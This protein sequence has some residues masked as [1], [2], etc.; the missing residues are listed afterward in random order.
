MA[1]RFRVRSRIEGLKK[2]AEGGEATIYQYNSTTVLKIY[3]PHVDLARKQQKVKEFINL[4][5]RFPDV[6]VIGPS[7][8][9]LLNDVF[10]GYAMDK[11]EN[12]EDLHM[13]TKTKYL[14]AAGL[15]NKDVLTIMTFIGI[16]LEYLHA[17]G[18][19]IGD[20]S[21][22]N[23]QI[24]GKSGYFI[25]VDSWGI[26]G[27]FPPDAYTVL[28][29]CP[30]SYARDGSIKFSLENE[31]YN[32]AVLAFNILTRI[33]PFGGTYLPNKGLSIPERMKKKISILGRHAKDI[34]IPKVI[35]SWK[36]I[37]P[38]LEKD[39]IDIFE[40]GKR[41]DITPDLKELLDNMKYCRTHGIY[42]YSKYNECPICNANA[43][44]QT[45]PV[46]TI[47]TPG[48]T[49]PQITVVFAGTDCAYILSNVHYLN[50]VGE[51]VHFES[52][53]KFAFALGKKVDFSND[54]KIVY[55]VDDDTITIYDENNQVISSIERM[56]RTNYLVKDKNIYYVDKGNNMVNLS[57]TRSGN[58][59]KY[60][61]QVYN[62][63]FE[64]SEDGKTFI[65]SMYPKKVIIT[66]SDYTFEVNYTGRINE[67]A[68]KYDKATQKWLFVYQLPNGRHRTMVFAKNKIE[69]DSNSILYNAQPLG[70][71]DFFKNTIYDPADSK[72]IGT[73]LSKNTTRE[74]AC[75]LVD[76]SSRLIFTGRGFKI[77]NATKVYNYG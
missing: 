71:I 29:T 63:I 65:A 36:W 33:H 13:L 55:L 76:E 32:F 60:L 53:R 17:M 10:V 37:S 3:K 9:V 23:F 21:D 43:K 12:S 14:I 5:S 56:H 6:V 41:F 47:V 27:K 51:A 66:T 44:I 18:I 49:G 68:I 34:K 8:E 70:N 62:P 69:Y 40:N 39:F 73:N 24:V 19:L 64:V 45:A 52:G 38:K 31:Y 67:Y 2:L 16:N 26:I 77:Y 72:I 61:G 50:K 57:I 42:Y 58:L 28:F 30:D 22:Y 15:S 75:E 46:A 1:I 54:G 25:D 48:A 11:L 4:K 20:I 74:F 7:E 59:P 35:D